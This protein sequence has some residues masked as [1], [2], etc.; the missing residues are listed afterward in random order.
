M[1]GKNFIA[2]EEDRLCQ[3][4]GQFEETRPYGPNGEQVCFDCGMKDP[5]AAVRAFRKYVMGDPGNLQ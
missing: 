5:A 2:P 3:L 1:S 4:C